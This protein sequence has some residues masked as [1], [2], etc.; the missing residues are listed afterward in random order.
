MSD[1]SFPLCPLSLLHLKKNKPGVMIH[2][3][4]PST[5]EAEASL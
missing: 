5:P 1:L 4:N 3:Y 2:I